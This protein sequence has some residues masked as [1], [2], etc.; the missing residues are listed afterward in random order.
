MTRHL[1]QASPRRGLFITFEGGE[2]SGK[3]TQVERLR[4]RLRA[5]G[6][7]VVA[8]REPG[9]SIGAEAVR[10]VLLSG[11]A[12]ALG[13][14]AEAVLLSAARADHIASVIAPALARGEIVLSDRFHD[15]TRVYQGQDPMADRTFLGN[16]ERATLGGLYPDLTVI[17]DIPAVEG[18]ARAAKRR[19]RRAADRFEKEAVSRHE[20]RRRAFLE[21]ART[22]PERCVVVDARQ[23]ADAVAAEIS[24]L[25]EDRM[26]AAR[27]DRVGNAFAAK[28][29]PLVEPR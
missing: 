9:G 4:D 2:G 19:G 6:H 27:M 12:E 8:T 22:E 11:A 20:A 13:P 29:A 17:L 16:L 3:S 15:S 23:P 5:Q 7:V 24:A 28:T 1:D 18:L 21:I 10:H 25:V 26:D 14:E